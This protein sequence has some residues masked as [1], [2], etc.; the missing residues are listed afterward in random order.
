MAA[1]LSDSFSSSKTL[2]LADLIQD[3]LERGAEYE[4][5]AVTRRFRLFCLSKNWPE[6]V[7]NH[8]SLRQEDG[9]YTVSYPDWIR[10]KVEFL[11][12]GDQDTPGTNVIWDFLTNYVGTEDYQNGFIQAMSESGV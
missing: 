4:A 6:N 7:V 3:A 9:K 5:V 11:E 1:T 10:K 8:L 2:R 12:Y